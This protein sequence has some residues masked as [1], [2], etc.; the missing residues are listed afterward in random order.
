[1]RV[2]KSEQD[3]R[4]LLQ[5]R[6]EKTQ[7]YRVPAEVLRRVP[8]DTTVPLRSMTDAEMQEL[9]EYLGVG[10]EQLHGPLRVVE[11]R[12]PRCQ[13]LITFLDFVQTAVESRVH[14]RAQL[15]DVLTGRAGAWITVRGRDG[16][17]PVT[18]AN[19]GEMARMPAYSEYS[20][21]SYAYA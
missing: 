10:A 18:C 20:S 16:G 19:C 21:S 4:R 15:R 6:P 2:L 8:L 17:R 7:T 11:A 5:K 14:E 12:C 9:A 1:V 3:V 13:R